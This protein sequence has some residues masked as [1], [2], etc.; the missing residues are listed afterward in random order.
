MDNIDKRIKQINKQLAK[1]EK[2]NENM[3][4]LDTVDYAR[5]AVEASSMNSAAELGFVDG[6]KQG[7]LTPFSLTFT[8]GEGINF[9]REF[10]AYTAI[11]IALLCILAVPCAI[12]DIALTP[13]C[14]FHN[15]VTMLPGHLIANAI[16]KHRKN[17]WEKKLPEVEKVVNNL[18]QEKENLLAQKE[19]KREKEDKN[20]N[21]VVEEE[22]NQG[23]ISTT[24]L[25]NMNGREIAEHIVKSRKS[26]S[27]KEE[28][29][30]QQKDSEMEL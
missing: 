25:E 22:L 2:K 16:I 18:K 13:V 3:R 17:K 5:G 1:I 9:L 19:N 12:I 23:S 11:P 28:Q 27:K 30:T 15:F 29:G 8:I 10:G 26:N 6:I 4:L 14:W 24:D 7:F 20:E 21:I